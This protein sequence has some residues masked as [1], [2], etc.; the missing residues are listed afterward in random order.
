MCSLL[1]CPQNVI[2]INKAINNPLPL[3]WTSS[4]DYGFFVGKVDTFLGK[5]SLRKKKKEII[6]IWL[7]E[8]FDLNIPNWVCHSVLT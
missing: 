5:I 1:V 2:L 3:G 7:E 4:V 8:C 6:I